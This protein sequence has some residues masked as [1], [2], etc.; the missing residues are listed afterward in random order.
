MKTIFLC[1]RKQ[2]FYASSIPFFSG[3]LSVPHFRHLY[4]QTTIHP[5]K[6]KRL[7]KVLRILDVIA[8]KARTSNVTDS[9]QSHLRLIQDFLQTNSYQFN[10][11]RVCSAYSNSREDSISVL[12]RLHREGLRADQSVLSHALSSCGSTRTLRVG[13]QVHCL[14]IR[15]GFMTNVYVGSSLITLYVKCGALGNAYRVFEE[16]PVKNVVSWTAIINGFALEWQV[17]VCLELYRLMRNSTAKPNDFTLA[18]LLSACKCGNVPDGLY[19]FENMHSKD[20]VSWNS[21][22][23]GYAQHG[24]AW[25]AI[26]LFEEMKRQRVGPDAVTFLGILSSCRH[27]GLVKQGQL[28]FNSM[29]ESGVKPE[30]DHYSC[31]VDLLGRA[32]FLEEARDFIKKM[33]INP[34]AVIWGSLLSSCRLHGNVWIGIEAAENKLVLEPGCTSTHLQ[35]ANLY[36]SVGWWDQAARVRKLMKDKELKTDPGYSWIEIRNEVYRFR[37]EDN[38]SFKAQEIIAVVVNLVDHMRSLGYAPD[39]HELEVGYDLH[40]DI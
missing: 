10:E 35:L 11:Q 16:M 18:S 34:N 24:L 28:Y 23:A 5:T 32:G 14:A 1:I 29:I 21:M 37:A 31:I 39:K 3:L 25:Q 22:I 27:V 13:I 6:S 26:D 9:R 19:I 30:I 17:D 20:L 4:S 15:T 33:P 38:S 40:R 7:N 36:A 8:P 2:P 12:F